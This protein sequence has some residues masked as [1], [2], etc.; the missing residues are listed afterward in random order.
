MSCI[1]VPRNS[2]LQDLQ[3][4]FGSKVAIW[5][6]ACDKE[7]IELKVIE[8]LR[9]ID[10]QNYLYS[11]GRTC[12]GN[13][14]TNAQGLSGMHPF[15]L[16]VDVYPIIDDKVLV[17]FDDNKKA[18]ADM[19]RASQIGREYSLEWG[20]NW[21]NFKDYPHFQQWVVSIRELRGFYPGGWIPGVSREKLWL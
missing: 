1:E 9:T 5:L 19:R 16:A 8:T 6:E 18:M 17:E 2:R 21:K 11:L 10:R 4:F 15:G 20:G 7:G 3:P 12:P 13:K 14:V